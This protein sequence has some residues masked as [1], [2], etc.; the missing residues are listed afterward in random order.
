MFFT[1][2]KFGWF[3]NVLLLKVFT[4]L[5]LKGLKAENCQINVTT[6]HHLSVPVDNKS[7]IVQTKTSLV[8]LT[9]VC[10]TCG[11]SYPPFSVGVSPNSVHSPTDMSRELRTVT[12]AARAR[13]HLDLTMSILPVRR[14]RGRCKCFSRWGRCSQ[15]ILHTLEF[16][17]LNRL[18]GF[19]LSLTRARIFGQ[20]W[21]FRGELIKLNISFVIKANYFAPKPLGYPTSAQ[22]WLWSVR[23]V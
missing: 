9:K 10:G 22:L 21:D 23:L 13:P 11:N 18:H 2:L 5:G 4:I 19:S 20:T 16:S 7:S 17:F 15:Q 8:I 14:K 6:S 3:L 1:R 12:T